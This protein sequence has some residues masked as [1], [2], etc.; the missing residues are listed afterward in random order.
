MIRRLVA[1]A[2]AAPVMAVACTPL[3]PDPDKRVRDKSEAPAAALS[4]GGASW[5]TRSLTQEPTAKLPDGINPVVSF[6][7][8]LAESVG[9]PMVLADDSLLVR[10][11]SELLWVKDG[12]ILGQWAGIDGKIAPAIMGDGTVIAATQ[13]N[14]VIWLKDGAVVHEYAARSAFALAPVIVGDDLVVIGTG[15]G[16]NRVLWLRNGWKVAEFVADNGL[17]GQITALADGTVVVAAGDMAVHWLKDGAERF[18]LDTGEK[19]LVERPAL[20]LAGDV[21]FLATNERVIWAKDGSVVHELPATELGGGGWGVPLARADGSI[22]LPGWQRLHW[23][24]DGAVERGFDLY[25][26]TY[27]GYTYSQGNNAAAFA[28]DAY[29]V[30]G[31]GDR[32]SWIEDGELVAQFASRETG[33]FGGAPALLSDGTAVVH[34]QADASL[35]W[36]TLGP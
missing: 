17:T 26:Y 13:D 28:G 25:G 19:E 30:V 6:E 34:S 7:L 18:A 16:D 24:K 33:G 22:M 36:V 8:P 11:P 29:V 23:L 10:S 20:A 15:H 3:K 5:Y 12:Q 27:D 14:K 31:A 9:R 32:V 2:L 1:V 4:A 35:Y 21:V